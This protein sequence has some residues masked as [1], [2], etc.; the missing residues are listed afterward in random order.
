MRK[1]A[2]NSFE[3]VKQYTKEELD[4][5]LG[6]RTGT[7]ILDLRNSSFQ[8]LDLQGMNFS[9]CNLSGC[10]FRDCNISGCDFRFSDLTGCRIEGANLYLARLQESVL[11]G[12]RSDSATRYFAMC[13]PEQGAFLGYKLCFNY[14]LVQLLIPA[15]AKRSS[16]T[17]NACRCSKAKVLKI[18]SGDGRQQFQ[19][20][21][22]FADQY[23]LYKVGQTAYPSGFDENRWVD[24]TTGIH[25]FMTAR[26]ALAYMKG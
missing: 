4:T 5:I 6:L 8:G 19:E 11:T 24:S 18:T 13:C 10:D 25:F 1:S 26:E 12:I 7:T 16:A 17:D 22:A 21:Q 2:A 20:A 9:Y 23:F 3:H 14:R 15:D